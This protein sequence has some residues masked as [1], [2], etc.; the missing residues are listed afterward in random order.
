MREFILF[1]YN[2][3]FKQFSVYIFDLILHL[4]VIS[5]YID[6]MSRSINALYSSSWLRWFIRNE[7]VE[8]SEL[9]PD[10]ALQLAALFLRLVDLLP[11]FPWNVPHWS[12]FQ[13]VCHTW[14]WKQMT[15]VKNEDVNYYTEAISYTRIISNSIF[16]KNQFWI[17]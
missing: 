2:V 4:H 1:R 13:Q 8:G 11:L 3:H 5:F 6:R 17:A 14:F 16:A 12:R 10:F 15:Y 7:L 9:L